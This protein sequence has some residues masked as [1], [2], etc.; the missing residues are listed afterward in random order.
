MRV[1]LAVDQAGAL[2][3]VL[4][5]AEQILAQHGLVEDAGHFGDEERI[6]VV[7]VRLRRAGVMAVHRVAALVGKRED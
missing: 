4:R 3:I 6:V 7:G 1:E 5:V 2:A